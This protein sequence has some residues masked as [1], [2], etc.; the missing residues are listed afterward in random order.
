MCSTELREEIKHKVSGIQEKGPK[1]GYSQRKCQDG[2]GIPQDNSCAAGEGITVKLGSKL[3]SLRRT[4]VYSMNIVEQNTPKLSCFKK[5][6]ISD[7]SIDQPRS[8][9]FLG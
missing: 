2:N 4:F 9:A 5:S 6:I 8:S 7:T 3:K 1:V